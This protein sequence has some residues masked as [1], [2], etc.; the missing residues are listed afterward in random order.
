MSYVIYS[1]RRDPYAFKALIAAEF[2]G[3]KVDYP[4]FKIDVDNKTPEFKSKNPNGETP[5]LDTPDG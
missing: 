4:D 2:G 5:T 1:Y 3:I